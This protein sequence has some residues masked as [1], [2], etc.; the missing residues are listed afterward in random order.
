M[1]ETSGI[2]GGPAVGECLTGFGQVRE[3]RQ[4]T[5]ALAPRHHNDPHSA[6]T[7]PPGHLR[8]TQ[9]KSEQ[10]RGLRPCRD[11]TLDPRRN[12]DQSPRGIHRRRIVTD[13][14]EA[15]GRTEHTAPR[16][17]LTT[18]RAHP[19]GTPRPGGVV[20]VGPVGRGLGFRPDSDRPC[21]PQ[22]RHPHEVVGTDGVRR[23]GLLEELLI[24]F[25]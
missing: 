5:N 18:L 10:A 22:S 8:V 20:A 11:R 9:Q 19:R 13:T 16:S 17:R 7:H 25:R 21:V 23:G 2:V 4:F 12:H 6:R 1:G 15:H 14:T 24:A 3:V